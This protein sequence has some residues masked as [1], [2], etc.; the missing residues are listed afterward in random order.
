M[1][2]ENHAEDALREKVQ[3]YRGPERISIEELDATGPFPAGKPHTAY[4]THFV[5]KSYLTAISTSQ[6][7]MFAVSFEAGCRNNWHTHKASSGGGQTLIVTAGRG[8]Y[9]AWGS[10]PVE[11]RPGDVVHIPAN[12][13]H[14]HGAAQ[15]TAFQHIAV[16]VPGEGTST[17]WAEAVDEAAYGRLK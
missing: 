11:L 14:W 2:N 8:Y 3:G 1:R 4:A 6:V 16:E 10:A 9:Q 5:G 15:D 13:K 12:V 17:Q 7:P